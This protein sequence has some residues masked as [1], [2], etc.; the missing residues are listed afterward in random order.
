MVG[1]DSHLYTHMH[2]PQRKASTILIPCSSPR[3]GTGRGGCKTG[4]GVSNPSRAQEVGGTGGGTAR[5]VL[6]N[7]SGHLANLANWPSGYPLG[8]LVGCPACG[9]GFYPMVWIR[10]TILRCLGR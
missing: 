10:L 6:Q 1:S 4:A 5:V 7:R 2:V 9:E 8:R 3:L